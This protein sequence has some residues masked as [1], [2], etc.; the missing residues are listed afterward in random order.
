MHM[1]HSCFEPRLLFTPA[2]SDVIVCNVKGEDGT[3]LT[4]FSTVTVFLNDPL[5]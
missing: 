5:N 3:S 4:F 1:T 2:A